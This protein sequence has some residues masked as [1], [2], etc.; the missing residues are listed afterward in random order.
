MEHREGAIPGFTQKYNLKFLMYYEAMSSIEDAI[1]REKQLKNWHREWKM[2]LIK[3]AN[4]EM[5]DLANEVLGLDA[6]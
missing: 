6:E 1:R 3:S 2:N 5:K 4:P